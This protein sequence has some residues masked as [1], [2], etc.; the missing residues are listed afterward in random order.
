[1]PRRRARW[2]TRAKSPIRSAACSQT[3]RP[4]AWRPSSSGSGLAF[5]RFDQHTGV[6]AK[7][8]PEFSQD[9][10]SAMYDEAVSFFEHIVRER[11]PL[12]EVFSADYTFLN[13]ALAKHY[14]AEVEAGRETGLV[15]TA[16]RFKRGGVMRLGAILTATSAPLRTSPVKRGDWIL[17]RVLGTPTPPPPPDAGS[18]PGDEKSFGSMDRSGTARGAPRQHGLCVVPLAYRPAGLRPRAL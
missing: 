5:Y 11:R 12:R 8:F 7:R 1:M 17:R 16:D 2:R 13:D 14:G 3:P 15:K 6:D 18:L 10:K 4:G 9:V